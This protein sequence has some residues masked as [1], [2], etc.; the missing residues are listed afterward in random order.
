MTVTGIEHLGC[1][2][3]HS[4][5][6]LGSSADDS[7]REFVMTPCSSQSPGRD[8]AKIVG[9]Q[10]PFGL[11]KGGG[12]IHCCAALAAIA[13]VDMN[14]FLATSL[15]SATCAGVSTKRERNHF[16]V[17]GGCLVYLCFAECLS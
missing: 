11:W 10:N 6:H 9:W 3:L 16:G 14:H 2:E 13:G 12:V 5:D 7:Y 8:L 15:P 1:S 4:G 17:A